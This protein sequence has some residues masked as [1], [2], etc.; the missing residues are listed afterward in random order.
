MKR[1]WTRSGLSRPSTASAVGPRSAS[2]ARS[3]L[4]TADCAERRLQCAPRPPPLQA[5]LDQGTGVAAIGEHQIVE[6]TAARSGEQPVALLRPQAG[7]HIHR[8]QRLQGA[9]RIPSRP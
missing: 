9:R 4:S 1:R 3:S 2:S 8:H 6:D 5:A 7:Q